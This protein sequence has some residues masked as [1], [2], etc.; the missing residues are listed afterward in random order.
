MQNIKYHLVNSL[1]VIVFSFLLA[2]TINQFFRMG[3]S[4][5]PGK[6]S[7]R[8]QARAGEGPAK[9]FDDYKSILDAGFF[10]LA[11][12]D[13]GKGDGAESV[14]S[15]VA[16]LQL[17]G[18]ITGL[19]AI[20]KA[21]IKKTSEKGPDVFALWGNVYGNILV[22]IDNSKVVLLTPQKKYEVLDMFAPPKKPG[23]S[24]KSTPQGGSS[25]VKQNLSRAELQQKVLNDMDNALK[26]IKAGPHRVD[27][28]IQ[29]YKLLRVQNESMLYRLGARSG[30]VIKRVNGHP[31]D[32][33]EK[34]IEMWKNIQGESRITVDL[35]RDGQ[36]MNYEF[37]ITE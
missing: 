4:T 28:K 31:I 5:L 13:S 15:E 18:T 1:S 36:P 16:D 32:S 3:V 37:T 21:L 30:D 24:G 7:A 10:R 9:G 14:S 6:Q 35:E 25:R 12:G 19:P 2:S 11:G 34:L 23:P 29:G 33:T 20:S 27:N 17:L 8:T 22:G 26:G